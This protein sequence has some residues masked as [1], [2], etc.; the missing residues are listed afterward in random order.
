MAERGRPSKYSPEYPEKLWH[1]FTQNEPYSVVD[2]EH[3]KNGEVAWK[4]KKV[5][6]N[7]FPTFE[8]FATNIGVHVDTMIEWCKI[9]PDFSEVYTRCKA[10]QKDW[11]ITNGLIGAYNPLFTT[12]VAKNITDMRDIQDTGDKG[13]TVNVTLMLPDNGR[14]R[15]IPAKNVTDIQE[16]KS[17]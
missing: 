2:I 9:H 10:I 8:R 11:L 1:F 17:E 16:I 4:D 7:V 6:P 12:F 14:R 15:A 13:N 5:I 3:Y